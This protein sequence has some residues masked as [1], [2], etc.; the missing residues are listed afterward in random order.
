M[1]V[2]SLLDTVLLVWA[3]KPSSSLHLLCLFW[4]P[5][6][7]IHSSTLDSTVTTVKKWRSNLVPS[8]AKTNLDPSYGLWRKKEKAALH[9]TDP[10]KAVNPPGFQLQKSY[11][12]K[13]KL[14]ICGYDL[15][16]SSD[17]G[18]MA[19]LVTC[20]PVKTLNPSI[21]IKS[22]MW[23]YMF[24]IPALENWRQFDPW[25]SQNSQPSLIGKVRDPSLKQKVDH[26]KGHPRLSSRVPDSV[27]A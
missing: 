26:S 16:L 6:R 27:T 10:C 17:T 2:G 1:K 3:E 19:Q 18:E 11:Q 8:A 7:W 5:G 21:H 13:H 24:V 4:H 22:W 14:W 12:L 9:Q 15:R 25:S 20:L 23:W